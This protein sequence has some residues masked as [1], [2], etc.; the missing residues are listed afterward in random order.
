MFLLPKKLWFIIGKEYLHKSF[1]TLFV[2]EKSTDKAN[3]LNLKKG[4]ASKT[5]QG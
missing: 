5:E 3:N 4:Y 2:F 1:S